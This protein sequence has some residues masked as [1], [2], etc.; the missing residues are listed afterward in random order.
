MKIDL[1]KEAIENLKKVDFKSEYSYEQAIWNIL[2]LVEIPI[3][4]DSIPENTIV[5]R[6]R[7]HDSE[8]FYSEISEIG[9]TPRKLITDFGRCNRPFQSVFYCSED[10]PTSYAELVEKW[11]KSHTV[12]DIIYATIGAWR[13]KKS[14]DLV[15]VTSPDPEKRVSAFDKKY[16]AVLDAHISTFDSDTQKALKELYGFLFEAFRKYAGNDKLTHLQTTAY[17]NVSLMHADAQANGIYYP[18]VPYK[19][20]G[21]NFTLNESFATSNLELVKALRNKFKLTQKD[22]EMPLFTELE[23]ID[24]IEIRNNENL[25]I[26]KK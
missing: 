3:L 12:G 9:I 15:I 5:F 21:V 1:V 11:A 26:W 22:G 6:T 14:A 8:S 23:K 17:S 7:T 24:A 13:L 25:I 19:F 2:K 16:G 10:R 4:V 20:Q 18:S